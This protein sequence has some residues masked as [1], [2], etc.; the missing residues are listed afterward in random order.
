MNHLQS[1]IAQVRNRLIIIVLIDNAFIFADWWFTTHVLHLNDIGVVVSLAAVTLLGL[2]LL[3]WLSARS[4]TQPTKL[5]WQAILHIAPDTANEPAPDLNKP[6]LGHE[7]VTH[8]V[9]HIYQLANV[10]DTVEKL[11]SKTAPDMHG[12]FV[13]EHLPLPLLV[14]DQKQTIIFANKSLCDYIGRP[15]NET[16]GQNV[17]TVLDMSFGSEQTFD[18][19]LDGVKGS[20]PTATNAWE[21]V[22]LN[23]PVNG[24]RRQ[25]DLAA[26]YN[27]GNPAGFETLLVLFDHPSYNQDDAALSFVAIA[28]HELRTPITLL[29]GYIEALEEE[30]DGTLNPEMSDFMHK[31]KV[32]ADSLTAFINNMLNVAR[33]ENDEFEL[34]LRE[35]NW[36]E[37]V[38]AAVNDLSLRARIQGV[39]ITTNIAPDLP[40]VGVDRV[41]MYEV[42]ANLLDNAIKYSA[43]NSGKT[44]EVKSYINGAGLVETLVKDSGPGIPTSLIGNLFEKF[45]RSHRSRSRVGG[46]GLGLYLCK[47]IIDAHDGRIWVQS[48][49][50]QG[51]TFGFTVIPYAKLAEEKKNGD[52]NDITRGAH[53]WIKNHSL[54]SR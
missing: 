8:L 34:R 21:R 43:K 5:I 1:F 20:Q 50:G 12:N 32:T 15:E 38:K 49:E 46:T 19:W 17:Y 37:I 13:A 36:S 18:K 25:F 26:Y 14:L 6:S 11:A 30:L 52:N 3:P 53:G 28:V 44:I 33:I 39:E 16:I 24:H 54:Y 35:D 45:Y 42:M 22:R 29:R 9:A 31:M 27:Q 48:K 2:T 51:S 7:M 4:I 47:S 10:A 40:T 23:G 41:S